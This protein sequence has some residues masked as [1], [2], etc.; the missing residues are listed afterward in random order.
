MNKKGFTLLE[1]LICVLII[2]VLT[3][4]AMPL[5]TRAYRRSIAQEMLATMKAYHDSVRRFKTEKTYMP[6]AFTDLDISM[7]DS[8]QVKNLFP[9]AQ[10][11]VRIKDFY[12]Y[13]FPNRWAMFASYGDGSAEDFFGFYIEESTLYCYGRKSSE[14]TDKFCRGVMGASI[15]ND[16]GLT[17]YYL[18]PQ[19]KKD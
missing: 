8:V 4:V 2:A 11:A 7:P 19:S 13:F 1:L 17:A 12:Y 6:S 14:Y 16:S 3:A 9:D 15:Y 18:M 10:D 5:Y